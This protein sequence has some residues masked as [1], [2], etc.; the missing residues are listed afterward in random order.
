MNGPVEFLLDDWEVTGDEY[1]RHPAAEDIAHLDEVLYAQS[2]PAVFIGDEMSSV[3]KCTIA[4][5]SQC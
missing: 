3:H 1:R 2:E 4:A 5:R